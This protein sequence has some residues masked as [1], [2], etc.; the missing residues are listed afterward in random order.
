V[1]KGTVV[2]ILLG[3]ATVLLVMVGTVWPVPS[4]LAY[5]GA[6]S[7][8]RSS[9]TAEAAVR[10]LGDDIRSQSWDKAYASLANKAQ[11]TESEFVHDVTGEFPSLLT[12]STISDCQVRPLRASDSE[13]E[14]DLK[15]HWAT[16]VGISGR[17]FH[18]HVVRNGDKW[19]PEWPIVTEPTVPPQVIPV[20]YLRWD[21]IY[22]GPGDDW[23]AQD[24][25]APHVRIVDMHPLERAD[26]VIILGEL[27]NEDVV[28]AHVAVSATLISKSQTQ[29]ATEDSF[30]KISHL[31]LPKQV[32]PFLIRFPNLT[33][34]QVGSIRMTPQSSS[35]NCRNQHRHPVLAWEVMNLEYAGTGTIA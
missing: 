25:E 31:L 35:S 18:L 4:A 9:S 15:L 20:N 23:G 26:G 30:D 24:V 13:A 27:L 7:M 33:L 1:N 16:V 17:I 6:H 8:L 29:I 2:A 3:A 28:P 21:V 12:Y 32:T 14:I 11:F 19:E 10:N 5:A 22:R 34:A